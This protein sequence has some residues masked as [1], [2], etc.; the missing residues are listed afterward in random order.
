MI[1]HEQLVRYVADTA[2]LDSPDDAARVTRVVLAELALHLE[3]P[4]RRRLQLAVPPAERD[5]GIAT[6]PARTG[7]IAEL[8]GGIGEHL[9][10]TPE[11]ARH[12][13]S[14]VLSAVA[15][16]DPD[17]VEELRPHLPADVLTLFALAPDAARRN[18]QADSPAPLTTAE[19][20]DALRARPT[21]SGDDRLL[22]RTVSLPRDRIDPL[23]SRI[24]DATRDIRHEIDQRV[25]GTEITFTL[26][27][28]SVG[29]VTEE[30]LRLADII[31]SVIDTFGSGG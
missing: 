28:R 10:V 17:L 5:A 12:L 4:Q 26:R 20:S 27:T 31:D 9:R 15:A 30:D 8:T 7:G 25:N 11:R 21:W 22:V 29:A 2:D 16:D 24:A 14:V 3:V 6:V 23:L 19:V 13:V 1:S 18:L